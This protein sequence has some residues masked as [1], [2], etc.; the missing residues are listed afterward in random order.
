MV[1]NVND[2]NKAQE[3]DFILLRGHSCNGTGVY[4]LIWR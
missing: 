4:L 1:F 3:E 2:E